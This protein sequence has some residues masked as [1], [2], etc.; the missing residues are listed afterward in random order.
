M[1]LKTDKTKN[2]RTRWFS[3]LFPPLSLIFLAW[4]PW[5]MP[6]TI[7]WAPA[8]IAVIFSV[9][10]IGIR[11]LIALARKLKKQE[12]AIIPLWIRLIRPLLVVCV[13]VGARYIVSLSLKSADVYAVE[14]AKRIQLSCNENSI[15]PKAIQGWQRS[16]SESMNCHII[17]GKYGTKYPI[18]YSTNDDQTEFT[19]SVRHN[20]DEMLSIKGG[21]DKQLIA[22]RSVCGNVIDVDIKTLES[23]GSKGDSE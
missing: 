15:C 4:V 5:D 11:L 1:I 9:F 14:T 6:T 13:V 22:K 23:I 17:Y 2:D 8:M 21:V 20:I 18:Y 7:F 16:D 10:S 3:I 19:F 12:P